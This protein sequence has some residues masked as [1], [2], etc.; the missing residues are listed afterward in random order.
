MIVGFMFG[1]FNLN[2]DHEG[3][4]YCLMAD[5]CLKDHWQLI[6]QERYVNWEVNGLGDGGIAY[7]GEAAWSYQ[8][9]DAQTRTGLA[10][11][12]I[13]NTLLEQ[14]RRQEG[15]ALEASVFLQKHDYPPLVEMLDRFFNDIEAQGEAIELVVT[16]PK[17][18][19][20]LVTVLNRRSLKLYVFEAGPLRFPGYL[21]TAYLCDGDPHYADRCGLRQR[22]QK[23]VSLWP[24]GCRLLSNRE[25]LA[26]M[27]RD[28]MLPYLQLYGVETQWEALVCG[29]YMFDALTMSESRMTPLDLL[30]KARRDYGES[31]HFRPDPGDLLHVTFGLPEERV[32]LNMPNIL[33]LLRSRHVL[34]IVGNIIFDALLWGKQVCCMEEK[35]DLYEFCSQGTHMEHLLNFY[36]FAFLVPMEIAT[37]NRYVRWRLHDP[38]EMEIYHRHLDYYL[39][40]YGLNRSI[41][42]LSEEDAVAAILS[43]RNAPL[44]WARTLQRMDGEDLDAFWQRIEDLIGY[45]KNLTTGERIAR[46]EQEAARAQELCKE[47]QEAAQQAQVREQQL[48]EE[49]MYTE[50]QLH[51]AQAQVQAAQDTAQRAQVQAAQALEQLTQVLIHKEEMLEMTAQAYDRERQ[52]EELLQMVLNSRSWHIT[53]PFRSLAGVIR[54]IWRQKA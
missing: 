28:E 47:A 46:A 19:H 41:F 51:I 54:K 15:G 21:G 16:Y 24:K 35:N 53:A 18:I 6:A 10:D 1:L 23:F 14:V 32:D 7:G 26:L 12:I 29:N 43:A 38:D 13:P 49:S 8:V 5:R 20:S 11:Y 39:A 22:Y 25:I 27:L 36:T 30:E 3:W 33:S 45:K 17:T 9:L 40:E 50:E 44:E 42:E 52:K 48:K 34:T 2:I 4:A 31:F 37:T